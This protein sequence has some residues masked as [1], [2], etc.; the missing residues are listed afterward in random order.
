MS[1]VVE[2]AFLDLVCQDDELLRAEFDA[3]IAASWH[4][5][6]PPPPAPSDP[7]RRPPGWPPAPPGE[8]RPLRQTVREAPR[9]R[10][11]RS[12]PDPAREGR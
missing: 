1:T 8:P 6:P 9:L 7:A 10:R 3:L 12:P 11:Q 4:T 2:D 5:P